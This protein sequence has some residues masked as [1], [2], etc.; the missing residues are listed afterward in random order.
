MEDDT[1]LAIGFYVS[2]SVEV[3]KQGSVVVKMV[4]AL[5]WTGT[6]GLVLLIH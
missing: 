3:G 1:G 6:N 4:G 5:S 2:V